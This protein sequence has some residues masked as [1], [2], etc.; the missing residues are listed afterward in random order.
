[1]INKKSLMSVFFALFFVFGCQKQIQLSNG[2]VIYQPFD[3]GNQIIQAQPSMDNSAGV[4]SST[5]NVGNQIGNGLTQ[6]A[7]PAVAGA[8]L[9]SELLGDT[10]GNG[11]GATNNVSNGGNGNN[12]VNTNGSQNND[13]NNL[14]QPNNAVNEVNATNN[15]NS[16]NQVNANNNQQQ[17]LEDAINQSF[18]GKTQNVA[19]S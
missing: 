12:A 3:G 8:T 1:M 19:N 17:S 4:N 15:P 7:T 16:V 9:G 10:G 2:K 6:L 14:Q 13:G 11:N 5:P 18:G